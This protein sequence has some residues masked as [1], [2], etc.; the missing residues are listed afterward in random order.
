MDQY[1]N[2]DAEVYVG[3]DYHQSP[4]Q[5]CVLDR[6]GEVVANRAVDNDWQAVVKVAGGRVVRRA[7]I[8]SCCGAADMAEELIERAGWAVELAH[9]GYVARMKSSP[10]KT[11]YGDAHLL[12]DLTRVG[13]LPRVWLAPARLRELR[14]LVRYRYQLVQL[15]RNAKLRI[16]AL[17]RD[18]R[19]GRFEGSSWTQKWQ[20]WLEEV[21]WP[22]L[23][24]LSRHVMKRQVMQVRL[25]QREIVQTDGL[26]A[27]VTA[28]DAVVGQLLQLQGVGLWTACVLRAEI[29]YFDRFRTGKSLSRF[30]GLSPRNASSGQRQADAGLIKAGSALL[31]AT[32]IELAQ[33]LTRMAGHWREMK[34]NL[35]AAGKAGSLATAAVANRWV[36][37]LWHEMVV[38][39][40]QDERRHEPMTATA[41]L[42][43]TAKTTAAPDTPAASGAR[44][45]RGPCRRTTGS[46]PRTSRRQQAETFYGRDGG[47]LDPRLG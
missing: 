31:R 13:Y 14:R 45:Q 22:G 25:L 5:V 16:G 28:E 12:A 7:A 4:V 20:R 29:G 33:R 2:R 8:E 35:K 17:L 6:D 40:G 41:L 18:H 26:L 11:D 39:G 23:P 3:L 15:R 1:T 10:D 34:Q 36:R 19:V 43:E 44:T 27:K 42:N 21:A 46:R 38:A 30:C 47:E 37:R 9:P 32:L 24:Q